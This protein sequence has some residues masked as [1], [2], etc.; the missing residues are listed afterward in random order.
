MTLLQRM[1]TCHMID[2]MEAARTVAEIAVRN[3]ASQKIDEFKHLVSWVADL[4]PE[5]IMEIGSMDG[6]TLR[7]WRAIA[8]DADLVSISLTGGPYG[9]GSVPECLA[10]HH[11]D[12]DSHLQT[13][14]DL[15]R[16][17]LNGRPVDFLFI[18][19]DHT[20]E[21]VR[22]DF[23]MY[24]TL[25]RPGGLIAF[26]D[27]LPSDAPEGGSVSQLWDELTPLYRTHEFCVPHELRDYGVWG[28]IGLIE[29]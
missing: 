29:W 13:T 12:R 24:S 6:G 15:L 11:L 7:A 25:V 2:Q 20:Y 28:G 21:G 8:P 22:Q 9:G 18:D 27:I 26:H 3:G 14:L 17:I 1:A 5:V 19:G 16:E 10:D 23:D 4:D